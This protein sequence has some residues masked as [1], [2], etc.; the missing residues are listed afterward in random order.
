MKKKKKKK[1]SNQFY[2][3]AGVIKGWLLRDTSRAVIEAE[4]EWEKVL[5]QSK[6]WLKYVE[7]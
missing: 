2:Q 1:S 4:M 6:R 5:K 7:G 3:Q